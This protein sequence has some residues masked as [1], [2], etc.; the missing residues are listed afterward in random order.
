MSAVART[1]RQS[2]NYREM[3]RRDDKLWWKWAWRRRG[4]LNLHYHGARR[5]F[6]RRA[7]RLI[8]V[9]IINAGMSRGK[10]KSF[11]QCEMKRGSAAMQEAMK[12]NKTRKSTKKREKKSAQAGARANT[13]THK[14]PKTKGIFG[15][16]K[17]TQCDLSDA[18]VLRGGALFKPVAAITVDPR[19]AE[20]PPAS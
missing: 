9:R 8:H 18:L 20:Q 12:K 17:K 19:R 6:S 16:V 7:A 5:C 14:P 10:D 1:R 3:S 11:G 2:S 13:H 15:G 4:A